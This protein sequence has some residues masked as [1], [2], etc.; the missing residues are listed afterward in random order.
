MFYNGINKYYTNNFF[1]LV[2]FHK[3]FGIDV[4]LLFDKFLN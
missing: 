2:A 3:T 4:I 1:K